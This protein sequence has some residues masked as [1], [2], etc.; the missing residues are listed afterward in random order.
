M[1]LARA[2]TRVSSEEQSREGLSLGVQESRI[3][4][5]CIAKGLD[6]VKVYTDAGRSAKDTNRPAF[7]DLVQNLHP[8]DAV[9]AV[10]LDRL[11][12]NTR[13]A[14][15][16]VELLKKKESELICIDESIDTTTPT[17]KFTFTL[18][19]GLATLEREQTS[20]RTRQ[21]MRSLKDGGRKYGPPPFGKV[22][23]GGRL[24]SSE[25]QQAALGRIVE[26]RASGLSMRQIASLMKSEGVPTPRGGAEWHHSTVRHLLRR[27]T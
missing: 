26:L 10:K 16:F 4:A 18:F 3:K 6:V 7:K 1:T 14:L 2:Y 9:V 27:A 21:V 20:E 24:V 5:Y 19:A 11:F 17:G 23:Q 13:D 25:E 15:D 12:R 22:E 8:G